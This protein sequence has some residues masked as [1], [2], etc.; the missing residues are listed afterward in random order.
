MQLTGY[1]GWVSVYNS[2]GWVVDSVTRQPVQGGAAILVDEDLN[3][4][5]LRL[6]NQAADPAAYAV[7]VETSSHP[8]AEPN[9][10]CERIR[11]LVDPSSDPW[12]TLSRTVADRVPAYAQNLQVEI[13]RP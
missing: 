3:V 2:G 1:P 6:Y 13:N 12:K 11:S 9:P 7:R 5:S 10:F 4:A 8:G